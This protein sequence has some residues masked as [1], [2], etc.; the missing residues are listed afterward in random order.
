MRQR[1]T[2]VLILAVVATLASGA[3]DA[4]QKRHRSDRGPADSA[5][6]AFWGNLLQ[7]DR[8]GNPR[9]HRSPS[10]KPAPTE[11][12]QRTER[13]VRIPRGSGTY[14]PPVNPSPYSSNSPPPPQLLQQRVEPYRPPPINSFGDRVTGAIHSYPLEKGIGNNPTDFQTYIRQRAN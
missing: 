7:M 4:A 2:R 13:A 11:P 5:A 9:G 6:A 14:I 12:Q 10:V 8:G 1:L 3:A